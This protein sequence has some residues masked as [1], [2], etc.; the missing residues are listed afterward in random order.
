VNKTHE[1]EFGVRG[2][3]QRARHYNQDIGEYVEHFVNENF[4]FT[5]R[6]SNGRIVIP[7]AAAQDQEVMPASL[8][9]EW[10]QQIASRFQNNNPSPKPPAPPV[11]PSMDNDLTLWQKI[12]KF[13]GVE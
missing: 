5:V 1:Y 6:L 8:S 2:I 11:E 3:L 10:I 4:S 13:L 9:E 7:R 12:L